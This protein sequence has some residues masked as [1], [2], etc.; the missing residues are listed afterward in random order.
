MIGPV[1]AARIVGELLLTAFIVCVDA[2]LALAL[3]ALEHI[4]DA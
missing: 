1:D 3:W 2:L 4:A